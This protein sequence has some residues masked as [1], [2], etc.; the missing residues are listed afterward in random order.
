MDVA[1]LRRWWARVAGPRPSRTA[2]PT[3]DQRWLA[4]AALLGLAAVAAASWRAQQPPPPV[5]S[6]APATAFSAE[7]A[8]EHLRAM[9]GQRPTPVGSPG[10]DEVRDYLVAQLSAIGLATEV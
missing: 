5:P 9:T 2:R 4:M 1:T 3:R 6:S 10:G 8:R 7:R